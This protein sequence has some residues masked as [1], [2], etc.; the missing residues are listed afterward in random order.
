[1]ASFFSQSERPRTLAADKDTHRVIEAK[2]KCLASD[3]TA[4]Q[5]KNKRLKIETIQYETTLSTQ[6][7]IVDLYTNVGLL[8]QNLDEQR[9]SGTVMMFLL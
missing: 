4:L 9:E 6:K 5:A 2:Y 3:C 7:G 8:Q 1:M